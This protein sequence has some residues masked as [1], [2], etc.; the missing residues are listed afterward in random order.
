MCISNSSVSPNF[1]LKNFLPQTLNFPHLIERSS[2]ITIILFGEG[3]VTIAQLIKDSHVFFLSILFF[4]LI[5]VLFI[6]YQ[7]QTEKLIDHHRKTNGIFYMHI[8]IILSIGILTVI[9]SFKYL[10]MA[11]IKDTSLVTGLILL[12]QGL[13][14][15]YICLFS[16]SFYNQVEYR[17]NKRD[18]LMYIYI[19]LFEFAG[20]LLFIL[21]KIFIYS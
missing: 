17:I 21:K 12:M 2:L 20:I 13:I 5:I 6:I 18:V 14:I 4:L 8:H 11:Y 1:F 16:L 10:T 7:Q 3:I 9:S 19:F 15:Y